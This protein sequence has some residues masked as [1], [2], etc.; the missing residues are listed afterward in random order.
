MLS[1]KTSVFLWSV[2]LIITTVV[3]GMDKYMPDAITGG[4][5]MILGL[6]IAPMTMG[7]IALRHA[8]TDPKKILNCLCVTSV[9]VFACTICTGAFL[10]FYWRFF[11][12]AIAYFISGWLFL[13]VVRASWAAVFYLLFVPEML[14]LIPFIFILTDF[15]AVY[16]LSIAAVTAIPLI[17]LSRRAKSKFVGWGLS[18]SIITTISFLIYPNYI[19]AL[20]GKSLKVNDSRARLPIV[21]ENGDT[22]S[23]I[24][25]KPRIVVLDFWYSQCG[26]CYKKFPEFAKLKAHF[27]GKD[28]LFATVNVPLE[29]DSLNFAFDA[30][31]KYGFTALKT[32]KLMGSD[33]WGIEGY[34]TNIIYD[35]NRNLRFQGQ[36]ELSPVVR[37]NAYAII[38]KLL[39]EK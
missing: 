6:G 28:V 7:Y 32:A 33:G 24:T 18:L 15:P 17:V 34:P 29:T 25:M 39:E 19:A 4:V 30:V 5:V 31:R 2:F 12:T 14:I 26:V 11:I 23:V 16:L 21:A 10:D 3:M 37:N 13:Y 1:K 27:K 20:N 22:S 35:A 9:I 38:D 36:L 8:K